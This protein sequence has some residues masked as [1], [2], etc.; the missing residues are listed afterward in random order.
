[1][2]GGGRITGRDRQEPPSKSGEEGRQ[3]GRQTGRQAAGDTAGVERCWD[4]DAKRI[5]C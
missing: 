3:A 4:G 5:C 2:V 1:M